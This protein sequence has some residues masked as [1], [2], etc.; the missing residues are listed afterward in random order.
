MKLAFLCFTLLLL[1]SLSAAKISTS[2]KQITLKAKAKSLSLTKKKLLR[3]QIEEK[4]KNLV[5]RQV[6][7]IRLNNEMKI[8][9]KIGRGL[10]RAKDSSKI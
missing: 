6:E 5:K 1:T 10:S 3:K 4:N 9:K 8:T 7:L 2:K